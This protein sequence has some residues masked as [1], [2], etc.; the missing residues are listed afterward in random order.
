LGQHGAGG[1]VHRGQQVDLPALRVPG[2]TQRLAIDRDCPAVPLPAA[3]KPGADRCGQGVGVKPAE[4]AA[5]GGLGR[6]AVV[7]RAIAAGAERGTDWLGS[8]GGPFGDRG[9]RAG[10]AQDR[11]GGH[12]QD[13]DERMA[14]ATGGSR[15]GDGGQG[16]EQVRRFGFLERVG[17]A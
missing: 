8:V 2:A 17:I 3:G 4:R 14:A 12:G 13:G 5:N 16:G 11:S 10:A 1:V 15:V 9:N 7:V 6:D